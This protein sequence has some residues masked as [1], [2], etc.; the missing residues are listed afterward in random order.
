MKKIDSISSLRVLLLLVA[1]ITTMSSNAQN[2]KVYINDVLEDIYTNTGTKSYKVVMAVENTDPNLLPGFFSVGD[3]KL[4]QFTKGNLYWDGSEYKFEANQTDHPTTIDA[5]HTGHFYWTKTDAASYADWYN[6]GT[7]TTADVPFF[8]ESQGGL[9]VEGTSGVFA[10]SKSEWDYLITSR[11]NA[12]NLCKSGVSVT[13]NGTTYTNC[14][15]IAPD[16]FPVALQSSY[17]LTEANS[18]GL[19]C[20]PAVGQIGASNDAGCYWTATGNEAEAAR[21]QSLSIEPESI[22]TTASTRDCGMA[23]RLVRLP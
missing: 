6:D 15:I 9:T 20:L 11:T 14:L 4:V 13:N 19:V 12:A 7:N 8:A 1:L 22:T 17:T 21:A 16:G 2:V 10:L 18:L 5:N 23:L 3:A